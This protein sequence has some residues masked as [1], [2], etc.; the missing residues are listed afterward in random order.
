MNNFRMCL[1]LFESLS[2]SCH[3]CM[4]GNLLLFIWISTN[5]F[6]M[7]EF[8]NFHLFNLL[9]FV[10]PSHLVLDFKKTLR[11]LFLLLFD[12]IKHSFMWPSF[13]QL[14]TEIPG[15]QLDKLINLA[16]TESNDLWENSLWFA[17]KCIKYFLSWSGK[18]NK[19]SIDN[20]KVTFVSSYSIRIKD[21]HE[22]SG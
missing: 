3:E 13:I 20:W 18:N 10:M 9:P 22:K 4:V 19:T 21:A 12:A 15:S 8:V 16:K 6:Q 5:N 17:W 7:N 2:L 1:Y 14:Q 11:K